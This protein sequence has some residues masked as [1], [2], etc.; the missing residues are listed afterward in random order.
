MMSHHQGLSKDENV[1]FEAIWHVL[2]TALIEIHT[3]NASKLSFEELYRNAYKIVLKKKGDV[4]YEKVSS[5]EESWLRD[6][7]RIRINQLVTPSIIFGAAGE[8]FAGQSTERRIAGERF[9]RQLKD[10]FTDQQ[11]CMGMITDVL[12]YMVRRPPS[13]KFGVIVR[14]TMVF[15]AG[16]GLSSVQRVLS[17]V[18]CRPWEW[19]RSRLLV[20]LSLHTSL[21]VSG[22]RLLSR[23]T[24]AFDLRDRHDAVPEACFEN[25]S[26]PRI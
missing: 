10:A 12:M 2:E 22:P 20:C 16:H 14:M 3:K 17:V 19:F 23:S 25:A 15:V 5:L 9:L 6:N 18:A 21:T 4:L 11:L 7:V 1:D 26:H 24:P 8:S 13:P